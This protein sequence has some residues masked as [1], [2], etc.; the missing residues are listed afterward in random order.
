M[1]NSQVYMYSVFC[2]PVF[3]FQLSMQAVAATAVY[4]VNA[5]WTCHYLRESLLTVRM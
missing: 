1:F 2:V 3:K 4:F 5:C